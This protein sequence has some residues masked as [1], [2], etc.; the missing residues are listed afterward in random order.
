MYLPGMAIRRIN[1]PLWN[2]YM[3][4]WIILYPGDRKF[5]HIHQS[6]RAR[7]LLNEPA[8]MSEIVFYFFIFILYWTRNFVFL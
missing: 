8:E 1:I 7:N 2:T 3:Y 5:I 6:T 4:P